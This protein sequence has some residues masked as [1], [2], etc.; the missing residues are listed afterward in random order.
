MNGWFGERATFELVMMRDDFSTFGP[1][2]FKHQLDAPISPWFDAWAREMGGS[3]AIKLGEAKKLVKSRYAR[4]RL[5]KML[6][7]TSVQFEG[8]LTEVDADPLWRPVAEDY[9]GQAFAKPEVPDSAAL[10]LPSRGII[11]AAVLGPV[12]ETKQNGKASTVAALMAPDEKEKQLLPAMCL[13]VIETPCPAQNNVSHP[14]FNRSTTELCAAFYCEHGTLSMGA[15]MVRHY[16]KAMRDR[17]KPPLGSKGTTRWPDPTEKA[18]A[19]KISNWDRKDARVSSPKHPAPP[20][21]RCG[22]SLAC[23]CQPATH[24]FMSLPSSAQLMYKAGITIRRADMSEKAIANI[25]KYPIFVIDEESP[26]KYDDRLSLQTES[27]E[28]PALIGNSIDSLNAVNGPQGLWTQRAAIMPTPTI[29]NFNGIPTSLAVPL[30]SQVS[31]SA[32]PVAAQPVAAQPASAA[33]ATHAAPPGILFFEEDST[34]IGSGHMAAP[35]PG[36]HSIHTLLHAHTLHVCALHVRTL[37]AHVLHAHS[38]ISYVHTH[39]QVRSM[40][41]PARTPFGRTNA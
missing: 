8:I 4:S 32:R 13:S 22:L 17:I 35:S 19:I 37:H 2:D 30:P 34:T 5:V 38:H 27:Q 3:P 10:V 24:T 28:K 9:L 7:L 12:R 18:I 41:P 14:D 6:K 16:G 33:T 26:A 40:K 21:A 36:T 11:A 15:P 31:P 29:L 1:E 25:D 23:C 20:H 39:F